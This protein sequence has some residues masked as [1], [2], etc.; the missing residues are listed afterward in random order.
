MRRR[1]LLAGLL[2]SL[3]ALFGRRAA[4]AAKPIG[5]PRRYT[6]WIGH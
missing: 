5:K 4:A 3:A 1:D 2:A 6:G